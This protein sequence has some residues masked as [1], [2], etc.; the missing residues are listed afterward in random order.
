MWLSIHPSILQYAISA[1]SFCKNRHCE[2]MGTSVLNI[3]LFQLPYSL[4]SELTKI[5]SDLIRTFPIVFLSCCESNSNPWIRNQNQA[6]NQTS[7]LNWPRPRHI[8][9][10]FSHLALIWN[11]LLFETIIPEDKSVF[12]YK[13][14]V[15]CHCYEQGTIFQNIWCINTKSMHSLGPLTILM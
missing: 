5:Q 8:S 14:K 7:D 11:N 9:L 3:L 12:Q 6:A 15:N 4:T 2:I 10:V 13:N 1:F